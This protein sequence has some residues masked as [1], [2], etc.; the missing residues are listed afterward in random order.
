MVI[1]SPDNAKVIE[2]TKLLDKKYRKK[3]GRYI[4]EGARL[5]ADAFKYGA[6][7][8]SVFVSESLQNNFNYDNQIVV[9]DKVFAKMSDT[10]TSQGVLAVVNKQQGRITSFSGN[11][12]IL[13][14]LQDPGNVGTLLRT[15]V[16]C[17]FTNIYAVN[18]VDIYSPKVLRSAMSAHFCLN[19]Y[20]STNLQQVFE[21]L[22]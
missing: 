8:V 12:L 22:D 17:N 18:C 7:I 1:T 5:V 10:V 4:I 19:L 20:E 21:R 11:S 9:C 15:A 16:A 3:S 13:D 6:D 14:G 2:V